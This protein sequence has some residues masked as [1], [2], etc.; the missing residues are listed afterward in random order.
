MELNDLKILLEISKHKTLKETADALF[1]SQS[2]LSK[3]IDRLEM[4]LGTKLFSKN[5]NRLVLND[6]GKFVV[7]RAAEI[8]EKTDDIKKEILKEETPIDNFNVGVC[9]HMSRI[10]F[11]KLF[12]STYSD[13]ICSAHME[14]CSD[15]LINLYNG[16][17]DIII[18]PYKPNNHN[19]KSCLLVKDRYYVVL[20]KGHK[21]SNKKELKIE[22]LDGE[23]IVMHPCYGYFVD[24]IKDTLKK[25]IIAMYGD[26]FDFCDMYDY[27]K[28]PCFDSDS[29][30][31]MFGTKTDKVIIP[32]TG[33]VASVCYYMVCLNENVE[34]YEGL[35]VCSN[36]EQVF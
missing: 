13:S 9:S 36:Q 17:Y 11:T 25:S 19:L 15:L 27:T 2:S 10:Q 8:I 26:Y 22:E 35:F 12:Y 32:L 23:T 31:S 14:P 3:S 18:L 28:F 5:G 33:V 16:K 29:Y 4:D 21:F 24:V 34:K 30:I 6:K 1:L 20:P 7:N